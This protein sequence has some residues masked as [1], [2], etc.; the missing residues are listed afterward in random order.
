[1]KVV[2]LGAPGA[3]KGTQAKRIS[4]FYA[5]PHISTGDIF[6]ENIKNGTE[7]G[8]LAKSYMDKG[9]LVP[10]E[11]VVSIVEDRLKKEDCQKGWLLDGFPR[12]LE[13]AESLAKFTDLDVVLD[14]E[15]DF[16]L[17]EDRLCGRRVCPGCGASYHI[18]TYSEPDC[19][20]CGQTLVHRDDDTKEVVRSRLEV[21]EKQTRPLI[22]YYA[23]KGVLKTVDGNLPIEECFAQIR[24]IL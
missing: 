18:S 7:L 20:R 12:T 8:Q 15:A 21:Y 24:E 1:M 17:L 13:Q 4:D 23:E 19:E 14:I 11:V 16:G 9:Q 10:D 3:G 2:L 5:I 22:E 6:R